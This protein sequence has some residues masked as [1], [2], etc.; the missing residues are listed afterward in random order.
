VRIAAVAAA[1]TFVAGTLMATAARAQPEPSA[2]GG[3][4]AANAKQIYETASKQY[5]LRDFANAIE[6]FKKAYA[7]LPE[8]LFL[9]DIA[10]SYR[11][12]HDCENAQSFYKSYLRN[13]PDAA[14]RDKVDK[15]LA[16]MD[17]CVADARPVEA[18]GTNPG[19]AIAVEKPDPNHDVRL[20]GIITII[21]GGVVLLA[22]GFFAFDAANQAADL[23]A[24][25]LHGC[26]ASD[27][28]GI[29]QAGRNANV[30]AIAGF[31]VGGAAAAVG[32][33]MFLWSRHET[34]SVMPT[35]GGAVMTTMV[36]F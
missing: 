33:G 4:V 15:F 32:L 20:A 22:G 17:K 36:R 24:A 3:D 35:N 2:D 10:Q 28:I 9:F 14:N 21:S 19:V 8:P 16:E 7:L 27:V 34:V 11:Q 5:D 26:N 25:C 13:A 29:D 6:N 31:A 1:G 30:A 12:L 18:P 23:Q